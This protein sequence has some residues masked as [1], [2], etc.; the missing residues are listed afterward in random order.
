MT[1]N[2]QPADVIPQGQLPPRTAREAIVAGHVA[3]CHQGRSN[4]SGA[5]IEHM[6]DILKGILPIGTEEWQAVED[7]HNAG[8]VYNCT[9]A[10]IRKK[11]HALK[12]K[13]LSTGDPDCPPAVCRAKLI[14]WDIGERCDASDASED[15]DLEDNNFGSRE[16]GNGS[17]GDKPPAAARAPV[18]AVARVPDVA[19]VP[20]A[21][22][23]AR[24]GDSFIGAPLVS[25]YRTTPSCVGTP[26]RHDQF[27]EIMQQ[28]MAQEQ[29]R[30]DARRKDVEEEQ[31]FLREQSQL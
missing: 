5:E 9:S 12:N 13:K 19:R 24:G 4:Y 7:W 20:E 27:M 25:H 10:N 23:P 2:E 30:E 26:N 18:A 11:L 17:D 16:D 15:Y 8:D 31:R 28:Q 6:L 29:L 22:P 21:A 1:N 14:F 3:R